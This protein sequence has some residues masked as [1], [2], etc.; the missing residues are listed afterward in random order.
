M[1]GEVEAEI[2]RYHDEARAALLDAAL[3]GANPYRD[4]LL[5]L[6]E[7]LSTRAG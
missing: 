3:P 4:R 1:R 2:A 5:A 7:Q 6:V